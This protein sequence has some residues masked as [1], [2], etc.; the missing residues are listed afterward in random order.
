MMNFVKSKLFVFVD[1]KKSCLLFVV[2]TCICLY[3]YCNTNIFTFM[4]VCI[5]IW[6]HICICVASIYTFMGVGWLVTAVLDSTAQ[7]VINSWQTTR[8][9]N[10]ISIINYLYHI[11]ISK[12]F[13]IY[14]MRL[15]INKIIQTRENKYFNLNIKQGTNSI[16]NHVSLFQGNRVLWPE[17]F[18]FIPM[19]ANV[20]R[21]FCQSCQL[22][23]CLDGIWK[24]Q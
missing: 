21:N 15:K 9:K 5:F 24:K 4:G 20:F 12:Y 6:F 10:H 3:L 14:T 19:Y 13:P 8:T 11:H 2:Y 18:V 17:P 7:E 23:S 1:L 16:L 22:R